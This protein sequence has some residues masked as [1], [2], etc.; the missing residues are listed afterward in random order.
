MLIRS[1]Q[2]ID[3]FLSSIQEAAARSQA[4]I[5]GQQAADPLDLLRRVK[6][7]PV[8][9]H[10]IEGHTLNL[11]EQINQ[12]WTY[13]AALAAA[14]ELLTLHPEAGGYRLEP[15]ARS[16][17]LD[18]MSE[19]P[20]L[21]GAEVFAAVHPRSNN[22]LDKDLAKMAGRSEGHRYVFFMA[23]SHPGTRRLPH[24][25]RDGVHVWSVDV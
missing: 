14:R 22:K 9:F 3:R 6:F 23:P 5:V 4:W 17:E 13:V 7:E 18:I 21:V 15:G 12:T 16:A 8:G 25:E 11:I 20:G 10:P 2:D 24:L 1:V 19:S